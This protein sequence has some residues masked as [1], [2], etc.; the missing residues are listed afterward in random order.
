MHKGVEMF[1]IGDRV[2]IKKEMKVKFGVSVFDQGTDLNQVF[3]IR[4][5]NTSNDDNYSHIYIT[6][7]ACRAYL[8]PFEIEYA[9]D[10]QGQMR[11]P[12]KWGG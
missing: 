4:E 6:S 5:I 9:E 10:A 12:F 3:E 7:T 2:V 8:F 1:K 11:L